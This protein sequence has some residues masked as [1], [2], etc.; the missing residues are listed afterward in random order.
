MKV[1]TY[2]QKIIS[3]MAGRTDLPGRARARIGVK[4]D[5]GSRQADER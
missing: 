4:P 3:G 5:E 2:V 1:S